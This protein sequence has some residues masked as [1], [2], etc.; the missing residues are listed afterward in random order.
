MKMKLLRTNV[1][2]LVLL[3]VTGWNIFAVKLIVYDGI[4]PMLYAP[5]TAALWGGGLRF[6]FA[7]AVRSAP[8]APARVFFL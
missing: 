6:L 1:Y 5:A 8:E 7:R 4:V 3:L 2:V